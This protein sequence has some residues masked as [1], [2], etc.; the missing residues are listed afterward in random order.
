MSHES[1]VLL[2]RAYYDATVEGFLAATP[3]TILG[4]LTVNSEMAVE[5]AQRNAWLEQI[6]ILKATLPGLA[7]ILFLES[8]DA[9]GVI[10]GNR[11]R[12]QWT[13]G[14]RYILFKLS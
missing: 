2:P 7:G 8:S 11:T 13:R 5:P 10:D 9:P 1:P 4:T 6:A 3:E 14:K 12:L